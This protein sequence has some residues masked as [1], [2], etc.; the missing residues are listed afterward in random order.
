M[1]QKKVCFYQNKKWFHIIGSD[2]TLWGLFANL[3]VLCFNIICYKKCFSVKRGLFV[4]KSPYFTTNR[5]SF[6][7]LKSLCFNMKMGQKFKNSP[8]KRG[9]FQFSEVWRILAFD[10]TNIPFRFLWI[11]KT[12]ISIISACLSFNHCKII[13]N[14]LVR[15]VQALY[16]HNTLYFDNTLY[17][18]IT[19]MS[20]GMIVLWSACI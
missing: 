7:Y 13:V 9:G 5:G 6:Q 11:A 3:K 17:F 16:F 19:L 8:R 14:F 12:H 18:H 10:G 4:L 1:K 15:N 2:F 20:N